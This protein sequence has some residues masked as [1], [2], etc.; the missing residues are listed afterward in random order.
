M[1]GVCQVQ[2]EEEESLGGRD[3]NEGMTASVDEKPYIQKPAGDPR[4]N[5]R[6]YTSSSH[7]LAHWL[8][9]VLVL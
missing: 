3:V 5:V 4:Y 2:M 1:G 9:R 8:C 6:V 7:T